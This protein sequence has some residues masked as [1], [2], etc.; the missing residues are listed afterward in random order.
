M[1][2]AT[3]RAEVLLPRDTRSPRRAREFA[4]Q[5]ECAEHATEVLADSLLLISE[6]VTNSVLHGG[7][8][9]VLAVEC[10]TDTVRV[11]VRDGSVVPPQ[12]V[13]RGD[14]AESGRGMSLLELLSD[15]WGVE[16]VMDEHGVGKQVWFTLTRP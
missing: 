5:A 6:L 15:A 1:C 13:A 7:S 14:A 8:P 3:A 9:I 4:R 10:D 16:P 12:R 2:T 11:S